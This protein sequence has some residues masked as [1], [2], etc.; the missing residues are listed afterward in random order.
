MKR[1]VGL[2]VLFL[3]VFCGCASNS[4]FIKIQDAQNFNLAGEWNIAGMGFYQSGESLEIQGDLTFKEE[5]G[6]YKG[7]YVCKPKLNANKSRK[8]T[9]TQDMEVEFTDK[10]TIYLRGSNLRFDI[11]ETGSSYKPDNFE[12]FYTGDNNKLSFRFS[13]D[14]GNHVRGSVI[15][16]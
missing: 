5:K 8:N 11:L 13:D 4:K 7:T 2:C 10:G 6:S 12:L 3:S 9:L 1:L 16:K 14:Y 15:R